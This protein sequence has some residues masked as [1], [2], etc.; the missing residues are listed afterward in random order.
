M[1][2]WIL[3]LLITCIVIIAMA[4]VALNIIS[5]T[6]PTQKQ[7]L[8]QAFSQMLGGQAQFGTLKT[9]NLFPDLAFEVETFSL[10]TASESNMSADKIRIVF[11]LSDLV[12]KTRKIK[13]LQVENL[14]IDKGIYFKLDL[15]ATTANTTK[16]GFVFS[17]TYGGKPLQGRFEMTSTGGTNPNYGFADDN[18]FTINIGAVQI[19]GLFS[20]YAAEGSVVKNLTIFAA[21][22]N[23]KQS[24][25]IAPEKTI[26]THALF[27]EVITD[28]SSVTTPTGFE[29]ICNKLKK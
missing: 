26:P 9:F 1:K 29:E 20:P 25:N 14:H 10:S 15:D 3:R 28:L 23:S 2:K 24:C 13:A 5:G 18:D 8:E 19:S 17:G 11:G 27:Q 22:K 4:L 7:G 12:L 16:D 6:G 21:T